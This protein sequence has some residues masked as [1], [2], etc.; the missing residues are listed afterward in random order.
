MVRMAPQ[1]MLSDVGTGALAARA[2]LMGAAYNVRINI[3]SIEDLAFR[4]EMRDRLT[5]LVEEGESL[6]AEVEAVMEASL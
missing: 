3:K 2:G 1:E 4:E 5:G 6:A